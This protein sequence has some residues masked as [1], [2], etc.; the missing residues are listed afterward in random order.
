MFKS[1]Y[2][3][4]EHH[5]SVGAFLLGFTIDNFTLT[6]IDLWLDNI[7]L[8][9]YIFLAALGIIAFQ[10]A[11]SKQIKGWFSKKV[12]ILFPLLIQFAFGGLF[13]GYFIFYSK[14][15]SLATS[16]LFI[17]FIVMLLIGNEF[18]KK[19]YVRLEFQVSIF[20]ITLFSFAIFYVPILFKT[21]GA[22]VFIVSG[23]VSLFIIRIFIR[24]LAR[25]IPNRIRESKRVLTASIFS[26]YIVFN[27]LYFT[28]IIPPIPLSLKAANA[29]YLVERNMGEYIASTEQLKWYQVY[30][31]YRT[32]LYTE[33]ASDVYFFSSVFAPTDLNTKI[34]HKWQYFDEAMDEWVETDRLP[35]KIVGGRD[36]GYR[37]YS[38]KTNVRLGLLRVDIITERDQIIGRY[39]FKVKRGMEPALEIKKL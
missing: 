6:R 26:I 4:Y 30:K 17:V 11:D 7:I 21:M 13:S 9:T 22:W 3:K 32:T 14:S 23:I 20:F 27:V 36:G 12:I 37:G 1:F 25:V 39:K 2:K 19:R 15:A 8:G 29:Y 10:I 24:I 16:W 28:N 33:A 31:K 38:V 18:F 34:F 5:L 35:Y